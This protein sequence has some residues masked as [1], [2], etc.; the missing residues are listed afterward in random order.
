MPKHKTKKHVKADY[1]H[2]K[3]TGKKETMSSFLLLHSLF[4]LPVI[5]SLIILYKWIKT[6]NQQNIPPSPPRLPILGNLHQLGKAPHRSLHSLSQKYGDLML[7]QL[8]SKPTLVVSSANPAREIMKTHDIIFS[9]RPKLTP[10]SKLLY[11]GKDVAFANYGEYWRQMKSICV[12]QLLSTT[13]VRSFRAIRAEETALT[14]E[15][16]VRSIPSVVNLT[17]IFSTLAN[18][19]VCRAAFGRKYI[20]EENSN[21]VMLIKRFGELLGA[22]S[23]GDFVPWLGWIDLIN[24]LEDKLT[25]VA[26]DFDKVLERILEEHLNT[27]NTQSNRDMTKNGEKVEDFVDVLLKVQGDETIGIP[28]DRESIKALILVSFCSSFYT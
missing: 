25:E 14:V 17:G 28:I 24:G 19:V 21:F 5:L 23:I 2:I 15:K 1:S 18:D 13:R 11:N 16:I 9:N 27:L 8:G 7:L 4:F 6:N 12:L 3:V 26:R 10:A 20:G 22:L